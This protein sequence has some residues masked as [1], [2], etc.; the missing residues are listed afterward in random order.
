MPRFKYGLNAEQVR[1]IEQVLSNDDASRDDELHAYFIDNGLTQDQAEGVISHRQDYLLGM[2][3]E[4]Q[5]PLH[6]S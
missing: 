6:I 3:L 5:G 4:G 1:W 2:Y